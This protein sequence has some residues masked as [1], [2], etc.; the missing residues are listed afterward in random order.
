MLDTK[1]KINTHTCTHKVV[2]VWRHRRNGIITQVAT[3]KKPGGYEGNCKGIKGRNLK[4][5]D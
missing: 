3:D 2:M 5:G 4:Y 1:L